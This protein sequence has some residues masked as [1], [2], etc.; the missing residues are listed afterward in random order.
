MKG[1]D[2]PCEI[3]HQQTSWSSSFEPWTWTAWSCPRFPKKQLSRDDSMSWI[4][5]VGHS[6]V[7]HHGFSKQLLSQLWSVHVWSISKESSSGENWAGQ[8]YDVSRWWKLEWLRWRLWV[9]QD[10]HCGACGQHSEEA[11]FIGMDTS[12]DTV[13]VFD[14]RNLTDACILNLGLMVDHNLMNRVRFFKAYF[15]Y[16]I[17]ISGQL[18]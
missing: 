11:M 17:A 7:V 18:R 8:V 9:L 4:A 16:P 13:W 1:P 6:D 14:T 5:C 15:A 12:H 10:S 2:V 3:L